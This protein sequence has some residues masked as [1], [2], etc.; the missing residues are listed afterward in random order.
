[1]STDR[2]RAVVAGA[3]G[4][5]GEALVASLRADGYDVVEVGRTSR[6]SWNDTE[7]LRAAIEGADLLVNLAGKSV[8]CRY[9]DANRDAILASRVDTTRAL[10]DAVAAASVPPGL[11]VNSSTA[12]IYRHAMDRPNTETTGELGAGF[13]VD[14]A[15]AW[16]RAFFAGDLPATRRVALRLAIVVG[17]GPAT[18]MLLTLARTGL[19]GPQHDGWVPPHR[20]YRGIGDEPTGGRPPWYR[21]RGR[22]RFSW[23]HIDDVLDA[24]RFLVRRDD[25]AGVVNVAVPEAS[26]NRSLM[27]SLRSV[28][29]MPVGIPSLRWML[30]IAMWVLR[31]EP[32]LILKSRWVAP[33]RLVEAGFRF[34]H[35]DLRE[36]L[37]SVERERRLRRPAA[38]RTRSARS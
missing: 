21:T 7:A 25:I 33:E 5:I 19:G 28:V 3:G 11:W 24:I 17:D 20:R 2:P 4:F 32:E 16:E 6:V 13:S 29:G 26:D 22:Q 1:M 27:R 38:R 15:K 10:H 14:V 9:T 23:V 35:T 37:A 30:E 36:A 34:S 31:T 8:D 18:R 12:T